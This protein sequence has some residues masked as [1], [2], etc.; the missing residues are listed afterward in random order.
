MVQRGSVDSSHKSY[1]EAFYISPR[2]SVRNSSP[3][4]KIRVNGTEV[5]SV[6]LQ[7]SQSNLVNLEVCLFAKINNKILIPHRV[8]LLYHWYCVPHSPMLGIVNWHIELFYVW[9]KGAYFSSSFASLF[10]LVGTYFGSPEVWRLQYF[11]SFGQLFNFP[12]GSS[13]IL[14]TESWEKV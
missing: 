13:W 12:N 14:W 2:K 8:C 6:R 9:G 7:K 11:S 3:G 10:A 1:A 4:S 5:A